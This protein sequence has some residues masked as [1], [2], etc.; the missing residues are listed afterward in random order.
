M[1]TR[2]HLFAGKRRLV[3]ITLSVATLTAAVAVVAV[4]VLGAKTALGSGT[5]GAAECFGG[6]GGTQ[7]TCTFK[8]GTAFVDFGNVSSDGCIFTDAQVSLYSNLTVPGRAATKNV[9]IML[10]RFDYCGSGSYVQATDFDPNT[11]ESTFTGSFQIASNLSTAT[12]N[13]TAT[14]YDLVSG[15]QVFTTTVNLT[16]TGYGS[17]SNYSDNQHFQAPGYVEND[18][19]TGASRSAEVSGVFTDQSGN[20]M[21]PMPTTYGTLLNASG[22]TVVIIRQ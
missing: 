9:G 16:L 10:S 22:G 1:S 19:F 14:M 6:T 12:V 3:A 21:M 8:E 2:A 13:G 7:P 20:N 15:V 17:A 18:R 11:G 4:M 5:G